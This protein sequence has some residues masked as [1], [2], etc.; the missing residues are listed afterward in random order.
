VIGTAVIIN[1]QRYRRCGKR[2]EEIGGKNKEGLFPGSRILGF[3]EKIGEADE[4]NKENGVKKSVLS[5]N[6]SNIKIEGGK[7]GV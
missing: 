7:R 2:V 4:Q 1:C 6:K 5:N 3:E